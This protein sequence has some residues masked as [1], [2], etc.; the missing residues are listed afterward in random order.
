MLPTRGPDAVAEDREAYGW[1]FGQ[2][3]ARCFGANL[4]NTKLLPM[5]G[6]YICAITHD[7]INEPVAIVDGQIYEQD[8]IQH[9]FAHC[10]R[11]RTPASSP[12][13]GK[14]LDST[15]LMPVLPMKMAIEAYLNHSPDCGAQF[16]ECQQ[17]ELNKLS[18]RVRE[19]ESEND[20]LRMI[21]ASIKMAV[22]SQNKPTHPYTSSRAASALAEIRIRCR[23]LVYVVEDFSVRHRGLSA[24]VWL[25]AG[26][27]GRVCEI[28]YRWA[29]IDFKTHPVHRWVD[30]VR[31]GKRLKVYGTADSWKLCWDGAVLEQREVPAAV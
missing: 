11:A 2:G 1:R 16:V 20:S 13:T 28:D 29:R 10:R 15:C 6:A 14:V 8:A 27:Q 30:L 17:W 9:W 12:A 22:D 26:Q 24:R 7:I 25:T 23:D 19:L 21:F 18:E 5:L 31:H 4:A 3:V